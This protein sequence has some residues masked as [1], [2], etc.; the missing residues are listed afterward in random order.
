MVDLMPDCIYPFQPAMQYQ[1]GIRTSALRYSAF[2][3]LSCCGS[4]WLAKAQLCMASQMAPPI[5][6]LA[7]GAAS[8]PQHK[9]LAPTALK[10]A[11]LLYIMRE[12][13]R[14][15]VFVCVVM[16]DIT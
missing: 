14:L 8:L 12:I 13:S 3:R 16:L 7:C 9:S 5:A 10:A 15:L 11:S 1:F 6:A 4:V 2:C